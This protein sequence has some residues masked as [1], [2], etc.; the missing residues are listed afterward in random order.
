MRIPSTLL[1]TLIIFFT[2]A[3]G[4]TQIQIYGAWH[5][6]NDE[7]T[8]GTVR[9]MTDFDTANHWMID[10]GDGVPSVNLVVLSF[11]DPVKLLNQ[12]NDAQTVNGIPIGMNS[13][14][15]SYFTSRN[16]RVMLSI[17]GITF[18]PNWNTALSTNPTQLGLNAAAAAR[19]LGVGIEIDY[20]ENITPNLT[21]LQAFINAYR[22]QL[23]YD[24]TGSNPA[25]R[26]TIDVG[27]GDRFLIGTDQMATT[28]WLT[29]NNPVLDY[30]NA[31]VPNKQPNSAAAAESNW[32]EHVVGKPNFAPPIPPL[33][34][35]KFTGSLYA[36]D[37]NRAI[38]ECTNFS[39]SLEDS[40]GSFVQTVAPA[41]AGT[42]SGM[43]G[44][45]FWAAECPSTHNACT[46][47][48]NSCQG[49]IGAGART[50]NIPIPMPPLRQQ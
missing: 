44:Y 13:A 1:F 24:A 46:T 40:T 33:A 6:G 4:A 45:M 28:T 8:W 26:L 23:P 42:T 16:I 12:T 22:S 19:N 2:A 31:M 21:G 5:C 29:T 35:A 18:V 14:V 20:E 41:G 49:G 32:M 50:Y 48:P 10:R 25:A 38:P 47:P 17:G 30:A 3:A 7:C 34:P 37:A 9:N 27:A 43:L 39:A 15:V 36:T 11:V